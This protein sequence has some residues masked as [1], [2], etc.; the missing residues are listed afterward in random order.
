MAAHTI[1]SLAGR[2][3]V[4]ERETALQ[5]K[6]IAACE[7][8]TQTLL[9]SMARVEANVQ[10]V[11]RATNGNGKKATEEKKPRRLEWMTAVSVGVGILVALDKLGI[12][13]VIGDWLS[14]RPG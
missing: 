7:A 13:K 9:Q 6:R 5:D 14:G 10:A 1:A 4:L 11:V 8:S 3:L 2:A 12:L